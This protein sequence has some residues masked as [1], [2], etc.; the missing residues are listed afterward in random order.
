MSAAGDRA[1]PCLTSPTL[2]STEARVEGVRYNYS[3]SYGF[4][5]G[6]HDAGLLPY[7]LSSCHAD[8]RSEEMLPG[9]CTGSWCYVNASSCRLEYSQSTYF[10][11][12]PHLVYSYETCQHRCT[13]SFEASLN[14]G[15]QLRYIF[16]SLVGAFIVA[17]IALLLFYSQVRVA[18]RLRAELRALEDGQLRYATTGNVAAVRELGEGDAFHLFLSHSW[19]NGQD[20]MRLV[21]D[22]LVNQLLPDKIE[23][24]LDLDNLDQGRGAEDVARS[25]H[26]LLFLTTDYFE[27]KNAFGELLR[28]HAL[29]KPITV[30]VEAEDAKHGGLSLESA[31]DTKLAT[32]CLNAVTEWELWTLEDEFTL[33]AGNSGSSAGQPSHLTLEEI[34]NEQLAEALTEKLAS[35]LRCCHVVP[36][37][38]TPAFLHVSLRLLVTPLVNPLKRNHILSP[39]S[40]MSPRRPHKSRDC[41]GSSPGARVRFSSVFSSRPSSIRRLTSELSEGCGTP[42]DCAS[43]TPDHASNSWQTVELFARRE[44]THS[45]LVPLPRPRAGCKKHLYTSAKHNPG[46]AELVKELI[47][48]QV[49]HG[50][51]GHGLEYTTNFS[52]LPGCEHM[53]IYLNGETWTRGDAASEDFQREVETALEHGVALLLAHER[54]GL[55]PHSAESSA[56]HPV[57]FEALFTC[58]K[59]TTPMSLLRAGIYDPIAVPLMQGAEHRPV[60]LVMLHTTLCQGLR[61]RTGWEFLPRVPL[62]S[63]RGW[64]RRATYGGSPH[65]DGSS[66]ASPCILPLEAQCPR[67]DTGWRRGDTRS[68]SS[69]SRSSTLESVDVLGCKFSVPSNPIPDSLR[70]RRKETRPTSPGIIARLPTASSSVAHSGSPPLART[71]VHPHRSASA[72]DLWVQDTLPVNPPARPKSAGDQRQRRRSSIGDILAN[73]NRGHP[74][75]RGSSP[76]AGLQV[77]LPQED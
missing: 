59:G 27:S 36:F 55:L 21:K 23:V 1:C 71:V 43:S 65:S 46:A 10:A 17:A 47:N 20:P 26:F 9:W 37:E 2:T 3:S 22:H 24:F 68:P 11:D 49:M 62:W 34:S 39:S 69:R 16:L 61:V 5:C 57:P 50:K 63:P 67:R 35:R 66:S 12:P 44:L 38:R 31:L 13:S 73:L 29:E 56:R 53:L 45:D 14:E 54:P 48:Q 40:W 51:L 18:R 32:A 4:R 15:I 42:D 7:C 58:P 76:A 72:K 60:S 25:Q 33:L 6:L 30:M 28:A 8:K 70:T 41:Q 52:E 64:S 74:G 77:D 19:I 75:R